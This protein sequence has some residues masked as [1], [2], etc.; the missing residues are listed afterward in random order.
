MRALFRL[1]L[2]VLALLTSGVPQALADIAADPCCADESSSVPDCPPGTSCA[3]CP[4]RPSLPVVAAFIRPMTSPG[5]PVALGASEPV[6][7]ARQSDI[8]HPPRA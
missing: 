1:L 6:V 8:F 2:V 3:C 4:A 5:Q 7:S